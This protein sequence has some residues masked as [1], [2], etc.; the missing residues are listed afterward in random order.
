MVTYIIIHHRIIAI[1]GAIA[2]NSA[3][4]ISWRHR[5]MERSK[6]ASGFNVPDDGF[7]Q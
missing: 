2:A 4:D 1:L 7:E 5:G 3:V 6:N